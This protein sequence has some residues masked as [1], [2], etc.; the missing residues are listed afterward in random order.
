[1]VITSGG[2]ILG[3]E[4]QTFTFNITNGALL[5]PNDWHIQAL[6]TTHEN[7]NRGSRVALSTGPGGGSEVPE[8]AS[9]ILLGTGMTGLAGAVRRRMRNK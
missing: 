2:S 1:V 6:L 9:M 4:T 8:P 5:D 7:D 3:G